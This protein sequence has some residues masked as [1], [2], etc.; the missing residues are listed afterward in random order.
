MDLTIFLLLELESKREVKEMLFMDV[1]TWEPE[2]RDEV[3][4]RAAEWK[5]TEGLNERGYWVD[6]TGRRVFYLYETDDPKV[7]MEAN[8][9][10]TDI[11]KIDSFQVMDIKDA[12]ELMQRK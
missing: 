8:S 2:K 12:M 10:W 7:V 6:L 9:Y 1:V 3:I 11:V 4:R 5:C